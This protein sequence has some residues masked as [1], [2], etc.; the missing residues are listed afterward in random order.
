MGARVSSSLDTFLELSSA[1]LLSIRQAA[2]TVEGPNNSSKVNRLS[3]SVLITAMAC[4][5]SIESIMTSRCC[6][7]L[8]SYRAT[9]RANTLLSSNWIK[10]G[11]HLASLVYSCASMEVVVMAESPGHPGSRP[12][13]QYCVDVLETYPDAARVNGPSH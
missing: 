2:E 11:I 5:F 9:S 3:Y 12:L 4:G 1:L 6:C 10:P 8:F 7:A 13:R